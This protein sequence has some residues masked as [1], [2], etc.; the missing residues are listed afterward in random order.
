MSKVN[1]AYQTPAEWTAAV[2]AD[3]DR[4]L[5][6]HATAEK[7]A[8]GMAMSMLSHYPDRIEL[9]HAMADLAIEEMTHFREVIKLVHERGGHAD[10]DEKDPYVNEF[11]KAFRRGK[12]EYFLDRMLVGAI[13]EARGAER[14]GL[15]AEAL[16]PGKL[17]NFYIAI[18]RSEQR[19]EGLFVDLA[20]IYFDKA[21][22]DQRLAEL[23][24]IEADIVKALPHRAALH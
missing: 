14:F 20:Y 15:I 6:D 4:F 3:F 10:K 23:I 5:L 7:K 13:I 17:K 12:E 16:E 21:I 2:L 24:A 22:V 19:H 9:V 18:S 11:R 8:S 1:L